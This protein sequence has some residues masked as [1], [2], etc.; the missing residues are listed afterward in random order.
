MR[1]VLFRVD[2]GLYAGVIASSAA[3]PFPNPPDKLGFPVFGTAGT[4]DFNYVEM[5]QFDR[6]MKSTHKVRVFTGGHTWPTTDLAMEAIEW[7][8]LQAM[9]SGVA[10]RDE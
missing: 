9:K 1:H 6:F 8:E 3:F 7:L 2:K 5:Q 10:A 4:E